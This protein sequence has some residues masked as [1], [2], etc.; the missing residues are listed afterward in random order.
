M[1]TFAEFKLWY[2][3]QDPL[4]SGREPKVFIAEEHIPFN[5]KDVVRDYLERREFKEFA[6]D[7]YN[8]YK[9]HI[10]CK[11]C[12]KL[13]PKAYFYYNSKDG[14][15]HR[16]CVTCETK[17]RERKSNNNDKYKIL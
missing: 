5:R 8:P 3:K 11:C 15:R 17:K 6:E 10:V 14:Y 16:A 12:G 9:D 1:M 13:L 2:A 4:L 7:E